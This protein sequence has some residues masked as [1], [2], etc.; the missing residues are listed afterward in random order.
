MRL[1]LLIGAQPLY[2]FGQCALVQ[3]SVWCDEEAIFVHTG[4]N[5]KA[6]DQSNVR[7]FRGLDGANTGIV[8]DVYVAHLEARELA[9]EAAW[10]KGAQAALVRQLSKRV[11]LIDDLAQLAAAE[12]ILDGRGHAL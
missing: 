2:L 3:L 6:R 8:R 7:S 9:V 11:G 10:P 12:E 5:A 1:F 4:V